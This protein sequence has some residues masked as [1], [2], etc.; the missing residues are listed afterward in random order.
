MET[1]QSLLSK[2]MKKKKTVVLLAL[3]A[4]GAFLLIAGGGTFN[5]R[6]EVT[7]EDTS[8]SVRYYTEEMEAR[9]EDLCRQVKG[10]SEVH[11]L[12][13]LEGTS[14]YVYA[15]NTS[16]SARDYVIIEKDGGG[17]PVKIQ[18]IYPKI[19]GVAVVC[20]RGGDSEMQRTI[21]ELLSAALGIP[22]SRIRVAGT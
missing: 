1:G 4:I 14:E 19:R 22:S 7:D 13:T 11:V 5:E 15:E 12:L 8:Y 3:A 20:T 6:A 18:E 2:V 9:I 16:G 10:V 17:E 21:T